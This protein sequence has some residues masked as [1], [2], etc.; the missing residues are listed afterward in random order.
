MNYYIVT[1]EVF[2]TIEPSSIQYAHKSQ[3]RTKWIVTTELTVED[4]VRKFQSI[5]SCSN[6]TFTNHS[7]WTG[8]GGGIDVETIEETEYLSGL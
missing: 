2:E 4:R 7:D 3:D 5:T 1:N 8:D 6:Y